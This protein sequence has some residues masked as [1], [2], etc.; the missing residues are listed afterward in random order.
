M[1]KERIATQ[2]ICCGGKDL[3]KSPAILMPFVA[4]RVFDHEPVMIAEEWGMR[5]LHLGMAYS[6]CNTLKCIVCGVLFLDIRF[7]DIE[8]SALYTGYR[9]EE[10][11]RLRNFYEPGYNRTNEYFSIRSEYISQI[12][13]FL[14][15][16]V[17]AEPFILDWGGDDG[18]NTP[19]KDV[20]HSV[21]IYDISN[22]P[23]MAGMLAVDLATVRR[24]K[25]DLIVCSQVFEHIPYP[26]DMLTEIVSVMNQETLFFLEVPY[27]ALMRT[28]ARSKDIH[29]L[30]RHWHEHINF[31]SEESLLIMLE[32][33][34]LKVLEMKVTPITHELRD[35]SVISILCRC[36]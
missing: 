8:M 21:H 4:K 30:K 34:G 31:F 28:H 12:E 20:A 10:Y 36:F 2:C 33:A 27:E 23:V 25:Y 11:T 35:C 6:V 1:T 26:K 16:F 15:P 29:T 32:Q 24:S 3:I 14:S 9:N 13:T 19:L 22:K 7:S 5:D 18:I 17:P